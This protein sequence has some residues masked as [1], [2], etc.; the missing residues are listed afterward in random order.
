MN[1]RIGNNEYGLQQLNA[2]FSDASLRFSVTG[3]PGNFPHDTFVTY[4]AETVDTHNAMDP[5]SGV[6]QGPILRIS[7]SAEK[8]FPS[9][10]KYLKSYHPI[11][12][13]DSISR[14][15]SSK[16]LGGRLRR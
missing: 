2:A 11:H 5:G 6:F 1:G 10:K 4:G 8:F 12:C 13:R 9:L 7:I 16:H 3:I 14:P 15:T